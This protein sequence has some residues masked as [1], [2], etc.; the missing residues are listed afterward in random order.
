MDGDENGQWAGQD[1]RSGLV[2]G[3]DRDD[4]EEVVEVSLLCT[5]D[6]GIALDDIVRW[7]P[8]D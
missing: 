4:T 2:R 5:A 6:V 7:P 1:E 3:L 8:R